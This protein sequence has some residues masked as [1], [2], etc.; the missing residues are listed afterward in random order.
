MK[1]SV[2]NFTE[3]HSVGTT[4]IYVCGHGQGNRVLCNCANTP[5][6]VVHVICAMFWKYYYL[7]RW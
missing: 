1:S 2:S 6:K 3:I 4:L 5:S 7:D